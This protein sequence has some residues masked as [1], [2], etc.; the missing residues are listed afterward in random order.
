[1]ASV[2]VL[3]LAQAREFLGVSE[4]TLRNYCKAGKIPFHHEKNLRGVMEYRFRTADLEEFARRRDSA[5][6][7][8]VAA[9]DAG[10]PAC[11]TPLSNVGKQTSELPGRGRETASRQ[12]GETW[13]AERASLSGGEPGNAPSP[14]SLQPVSSSQPLRGE[15]CLHWARQLVQHLQEEVLFLKEQLQ[16]RDR[17]IAAKDRQLERQLERS[18]AL[19]ESLA[20]MTLESKPVKRSAST[21]GKSGA[22]GG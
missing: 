9:T 7:G 6:A 4:K 22:R 18:S 17:Q 16:E 2:S 15:D 11:D 8:G 13:S 10:V 5:K 12:Y 20:A 14:E 21:P 19:N 1:M 3:N